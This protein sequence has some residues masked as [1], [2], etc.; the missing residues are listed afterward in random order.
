M[1]TCGFFFAWYSSNLH[2]WI[3]WQTMFTD[4]DFWTCFRV[5]SRR[6]SCLFLMQCCPRAQQSRASSLDTPPVS[7]NLLMILCTVDEG[8]STSLQFYIEGHFPEIVPQFL[9]TVCHRLKSLHHL[10]TWESLLLWN[11]LFISSRV[12]DLV[13]VYLSC[14]QMFLHLFFDLQPKIFPV[15]CCPC[16]NFS[17]M[18]CCHQPQNELIFSMK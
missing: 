11:D 17:E 14:C 4:R 12:T 9:D 10:C 1:F 18:C 7:K 8:S 6:E 5:M 15:F 3:A 2:L 16:S 13:P